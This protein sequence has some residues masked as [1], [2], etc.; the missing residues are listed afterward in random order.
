MKVLF[1]CSGAGSCR[2]LIAKTILK[3][4]NP[5]LDVYAA[6]TAPVTELNPIAFEAMQTLGYQMQP[7]QIRTVGEFR[8]DVFDYVVTL[9]EGTKEEFER[10]NLNYRKKVHLGFPDPGKVAGDDREI[11]AAY[12]QYIEE[13]FNELDYFYHR[14]LKM[15]ARQ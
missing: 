12:L 9:C 7:E 5:E 13:V 2:S 10:L 15:K 8:S 6:E 3:S 14:I 1:L 11:R 4:L